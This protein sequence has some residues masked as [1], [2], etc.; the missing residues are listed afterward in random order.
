MTISPIIRPTVT[1]GTTGGV[2]DNHSRIVENGR[3]DASRGN[4]GSRLPVA[5]A[6]PPVINNAT[7]A[8][9]RPAARAAF[10]LTRRSP[11]GQS[12]VITVPSARLNSLMHTRPSAF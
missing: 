10:N 11:T 5:A 12:C 8:A 7:A 1:L 4:R 3:I 6:S 2:G 9:I